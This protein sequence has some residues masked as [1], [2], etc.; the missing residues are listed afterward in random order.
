LNTLDAP[1][2]ILS[3]NRAAVRS[4]V[5]VAVM[6][7]PPYA[8][9]D[10]ECKV[11]ADTMIAEPGSFERAVTLVNHGKSNEARRYVHC[12]RGKGTRM[13][14]TGKPKRGHEMFVPVTTGD[15]SGE[16]YRPYLECPGDKQK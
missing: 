7:S 14:V 8:F 5:A 10:I 16:T 9:S 2:S 1:C 13:F 15:C 12:L 6:L 3:M 4:L 11:K